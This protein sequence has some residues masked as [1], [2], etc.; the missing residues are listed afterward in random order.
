MNEIKI[1]DNPNFGAVR[2]V[3]TENNEPLFCLADVCQALDLRAGH[4]KERLSK[5]VVSTEPLMT[6]GGIQQ[7]NFVNEDGLYDVILD[8]RKP[9]AKQFRKWV[10]REVL[11]QI[12]KTGGYIKTENDDTP[13]VIMAKAL[14]LAQKTIESQKQRNQFLEQAK[15]KLEQ[16]NKIL[17]PKA[18]YTDKVLNSTDNYTFSEVAKELR[19]R[20]SIS[21]HNKCRE[22][23]I[24]FKQGNVYLPYSKYST[25]GYFATRT[26]PFLRRDGTSGS[27]SGLVITELGRAFLRKKLQ[28]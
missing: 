2:I 15:E 9:E 16:E 1:F 10:T 18:E 13:D 23:G 20:S 21:L 27:S 14:I 26:Y 6:T 28:K 3:T 25:Q 11:P 5:D 4:V 19:F 12:R 22:L 7:V 17:L 24:I 8:S